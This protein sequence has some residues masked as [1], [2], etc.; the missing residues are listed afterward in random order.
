M[1]PLTS[2]SWPARRRWPAGTACVIAALLMPL[3]A[4]AQR[5]NFAQSPLFLGTTVKPNVLIVYDNS[6]SMDGTMAGKLIAGDDAT[7]RGNIARSVLRSTITSFRN[8]F[9]WGLASFELTSSGV[10]TTY[11]YYFGSDSQVVYTN[12]CVNGLSASNANL[13]C[14]ANPQPGNGYA[15]LTYALT[16]DDPAINDV[17]YAGDYGPQLYGI[18]VNNS[19]NYAVYTS[20]GAGSGWASSSFSGGQGTWGFTPTDAGFLPQTPPNSRMFWLR[21]AWGYYGDIS[22]KGKVN[23]GVAADSTTQYNALMALL[24]AETN[25]NATGELKNAAVFTPL[26]GTLD[27]V[28]SYFANTLSGKPTPISQSCQRNFVLLATDGNPTGT[29]S[30]AMYSLAQQVNTYN[31]ATNSWTFGTAANDVFS[32]ITSLR[33]TAYNTYP[34]DIQTYVI[35]LGDT[36][37]NASSVAA[38]NQMAYLGGTDAA[39]LANNSAALAN[40]FNLISIDIIAK[41]AAASAVSLNSSSWNSGSRVYQGRFSSGEWSG[42]LLS[43]AVGDTGQPA[44]TSTWDSGQVLN[45]QHWSTGRQ[46]ITYKPS[47][48][49]GSRGVAFRWPANAN[50][51]AATEIDTGMVSALNND[52][53]GTADGFGAQRLEFLRGNTAREMRNCSNCTTPV[54]RNR[55]T[56]VL[57]DIIDSAPVYIGSGTGD[58][59][60]TIETGRYSTYATTRSGMTPTI[61]VGANDGMLHAF[62]AVSGGELFAYVPWAVRNRLSALTSSSYA[63]Q[64]TVDGSPAVGDV[65]I[66][67]AWRTMLVSGMNAGAPG[68]FALDVSDPSQFTEAN[69][70]SVVRWEVGDSDADVG[71]IFGRPILAKMRDGV[72]RA[73][74]GNGYNSANGVAV[75]LLVDLQSGAITRISTGTGSAGTPNGLSGAA[76]LS[77]NDDGIVDYVYAGDLY[78][79]LWKFDLTSTTSAG[80]RAAFGSARP[81]FAAG[82]SHPITAR[83]DIAKFP[84]GGYM[85]TVGTGRYMDVGDNAAGTTQTL[86]GIWDKDDGS[87]T[88]ATADLQTQ[89]IAG[90][91]GGANG[92]TYRLSTHA[93]GPASDVVLT[94]DNA[95]SLANYYATK[96][97]WKLDLPSSGERIVAD[98]TVRFGH[99]V[100]STLIPSTAVCS[101]GGDGWIMDLDV[102]TG[103][104]WAALDTN[105]DNLVDANDLINGSMASGVRV[106]AVPAAASIMRSRT[107]SLDDKLIN[108]SAGTIVRVRET[109]NAVPSRRASWEQL[110]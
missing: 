28:K 11:P 101:A 77:K 51:P 63:H 16:G 108:T 45:G 96:K 49:L 36:V 25:N 80:W 67:G 31:A 39:Y 110:R 94:G 79:N 14:V 5:I 1:K 15:Y 104:R 3:A 9:Q 44:S 74:V 76:A 84:Q 60:D 43:F 75:L 26:A 34:Y 37:A 30:G 73:I 50:A 53:T 57:G 72:W 58:F 4:A 88:V 22:G 17:L 7:T 86:Y 91:V 109:G 68:L 23:Q 59:R 97:G 21:R 105:G 102:I 32:R 20:H 38:L 2:P 95:I 55:P 56:S 52:I 78:G 41:T 40:A 81:L 82:A 13:R 100:A 92:G 12:D 103:N 83:P 46:I 64:Y 42:Q 29:S 69:A 6:Q 70:S 89:T 66:G 18:G 98:T 71:Y 65:Y 90:T 8:S 106:G 19:T 99:I 24:A 54:F 85:V 27:T 62:N 87:T 35:G 33:T 107:R 10:Y 48:A 93:V 47:A 61:F